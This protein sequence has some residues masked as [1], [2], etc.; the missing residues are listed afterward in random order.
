ME[1]D[2]EGEEVWVAVMTEVSVLNLDMLNLSTQ[3]EQCSRQ[4]DILLQ[5]PGKK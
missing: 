4:L 5:I 2:N 1:A 3:V